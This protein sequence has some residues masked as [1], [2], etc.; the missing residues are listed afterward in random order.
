MHAETAQE[1]LSHDAIPDQ[2]QTPPT[3]HVQPDCAQPQNTSLSCMFLPVSRAL[4]S[5]R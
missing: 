2:T 1:R 4:K 3:M 5:L